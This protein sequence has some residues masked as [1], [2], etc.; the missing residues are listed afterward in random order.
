MSLGSW[1]SALRKRRNAKEIERAQAM[2]L[3]TPAE[4]AESAGDIEG[5]QGDERA[6]RLAGEASIKDTTRLG[7]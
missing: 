4:R 3:E 5:M 6:A 1:L 2:E 7:N